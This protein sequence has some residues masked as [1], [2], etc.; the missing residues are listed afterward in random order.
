MEKLSSYEK[1]KDFIVC[2]DSDG[3]AIDTMDIKHIQCFGPCLI[4]PWALE[5]WQ[6]Q[7][8]ARWNEINLYSITRGINRFKGLAMMLKEINE[9]YCSID[10]IEDFS[11]WVEESKELSNTA[12]EEAIK[13]SKLEI[14]KKALQ[15]SKAV[16]E[17]VANLA[18]DFIQPFN[19]VL[20]AVEKIHKFADIAIVSSA[21]EKAVE[22]EWEKCGLLQ[23]VDILLAQNVGSKAYC[24]GELVKKGYDKNKVLMI[25][26]A[27]G[28]LNA[29]KENDVNFYPILVKKEDESWK[30]FYEE[31][32]DIFINRNYKEEYAHIADENFR[33]NLK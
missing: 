14:F 6:T 4:S 24:I 12:L 17:E 20:E 25:G 23:Y 22:E 33:N 19:G 32:L 3:C 26:D 18:K 11:K 2:I 13:T 30:L 29:A 21:N 31:I 10:G 27:L 15:W 8:L 5:P 9:K 16:N 7:I 1:K 28:D